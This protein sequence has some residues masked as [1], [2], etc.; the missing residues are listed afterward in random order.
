MGAL[1]EGQGV[2][3]DVFIVSQY[4]VWPRVLL[5]AAFHCGIVHTLPAFTDTLAGA[6]GLTNSRLL[7]PREEGHVHG[8]HVSSCH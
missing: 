2:L 8:G 3:L 1:S 4:P 5:D 6:V 7:L